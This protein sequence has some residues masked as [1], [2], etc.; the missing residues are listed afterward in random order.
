MSFSVPLSL[1][2]VIL[3]HPWKHLRG[4]H[5]SYLCAKAAYQGDV[6]RQVPQGTNSFTLL[7]FGKPNLGA[8]NHALEE[9][10]SLPT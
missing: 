6:G 5:T 1:F 8:L 3:S 4:I 10:T 9:L 7:V 2:I